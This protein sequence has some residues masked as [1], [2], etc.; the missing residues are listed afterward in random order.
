MMIPCRMRRRGFLA[1]LGLYT[2]AF[3]ASTVRVCSAFVSSQKLC[4]PQRPNVGRRYHQLSSLAMVARTK[5]KDRGKEFDILAKNLKLEPMQLTGLL[6]KQRTKLSDDSEKG[7]YIDWLLGRTDT[8]QSNVDATKLQTSTSKIKKQTK[9][10]TTKN[11]L[12]ER[13]KKASSSSS[14]QPS[15]L[16]TENFAE[17]KDLHPSSKRALT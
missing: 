10:K 6:T 9:S 15:F 7:R 5:G 14:S 8:F 16:T 1:V 12:K 17:R 11:P 13:T 3:A 4:K 2:Q